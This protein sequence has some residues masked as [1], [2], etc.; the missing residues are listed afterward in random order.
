MYDAKKDE[1]IRDRQLQCNCIGDRSYFSMC[2][3]N[4]NMVNTK[5]SSS[6]VEIIVKE[7]S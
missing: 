7:F 5:A 6:P 1:R 4:N 3:H 2:T